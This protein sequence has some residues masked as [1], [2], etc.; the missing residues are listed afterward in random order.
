ML[1]SISD[2][3]KEWG[4]EWEGRIQDAEMLL[5]YRS[6]LRTFL[7]TI[8]LSVW[9]YP[10]YV[11]VALDNL[12]GILAQSGLFSP[13]ELAKLLPMVAPRGFEPLSRP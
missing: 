5:E 12:G 1:A 2:R 13:G 3:V 8:G 6:Q 11:T 7:M 9:V 4:K 10:E